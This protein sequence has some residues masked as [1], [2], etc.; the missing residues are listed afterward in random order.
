VANFPYAVNAENVVRQPEGSQVS[1]RQITWIKS[2]FEPGEADNF[3]I[4][5]MPPPQWTHLAAARAAVKS[6]P[7]D[8]QAWNALGNAYLSLAQDIN[9]VTFQEIYK[10]ENNDWYVEQGTLAYQKAAELAPDSRRPHIGI[11]YLLLAKYLPKVPT[12]QVEAIQ[13][14][15][16]AVE[17]LPEDA[18]PET[19]KADADLLRTVSWSFGYHA[20]RFLEATSATSTKTSG[21]RPTASA[22]PRPALTAAPRADFTHVPSAAALPAP[23]LQVSE[24]PT[25]TLPAMA[26]SSQAAERSQPGRLILRL[27]GAGVLLLLALVL[28]VGVL[29][30]RQ[31]TP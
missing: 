19:A 28:W 22:A 4:K 10:P 3:W 21:P 18:D 20:R 5:I 26:L 30:G 17:S 13:A 29:A 23:A 11:A 9:R 24:S 15:L 1:G 25:S 31:R 6:R 14:E 7:S 12:G 8:A 2:D 16:T 27:S